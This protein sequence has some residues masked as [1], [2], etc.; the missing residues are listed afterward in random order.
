MKGESIPLSRE[1]FITSVCVMNV[2]LLQSI[3]FPYQKKSV[4]WNLWC[5]SP[6]PPPTSESEPLCAFT[7]V[8]DDQGVSLSELLQ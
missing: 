3:V 5:V 4:S 6:P 1:V 7:E 2:S 8:L